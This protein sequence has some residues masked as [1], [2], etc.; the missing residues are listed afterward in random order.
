M[1]AMQE[2]VSVVVI[3]KARLRVV[4]LPELLVW[5]PQEAYRA[6]HRLLKLV[7][8][9]GWHVVKYRSRYDREDHSL[10]VTMYVMVQ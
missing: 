1:D 2:A 3:G 8:Q 6:Q 7:D 10:R 4:C 9:S 5:S